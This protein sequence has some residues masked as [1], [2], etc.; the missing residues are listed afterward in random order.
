M[1]IFVIKAPKAASCYDFN[2]TLPGIPEISQFSNN[3]A[4]ISVSQAKKLLSYNRVLNSFSADPTSLVNPETLKFIDTH[5]NNVNSI[6]QRYRRISITL[7]LRCLCRL[8]LDSLEQAQIIIKYVDYILGSYIGSDEE[9]KLNSTTD[10]IA[11]FHANTFYRAI[12]DLNSSIPLNLTALAVYNWVTG[13]K[14]WSTCADFYNGLN[15]MN[16]FI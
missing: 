3:D 6:Q 13:T 16:Y 15:C 5:R 10:S 1:L 11:S 12:S 4:S 8:E 2:S 14:N 9:S 7:Y